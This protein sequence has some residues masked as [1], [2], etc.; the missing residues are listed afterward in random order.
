MLTKFRPA[1]LLPD[2]GGL[3]AL[4]S[5]ILL[6]L[7]SGGRSLNDG[8]TFWH[9]AAGQRMLLDGAILTRDVFSHTASGKPWTAH[10]WLSEIIMATIHGFSG[11]SGV[12]VFFFLLATLSFWLLYI[13]V[14]AK[15]S[16]WF[17]LIFVIL[18][19]VLSLN[20]LLARPHIF[21]WFLGGLSFFLLLK[22]NR[23]LLWLPLITIV[24]ANLHGGFILGLVLQGIFILGHYLECGCPRGKTTFLNW[25]RNQKY[26]L[27]VF[28]MSIVAVGLNPFGYSL[29]LFPFQVS[30][31]IFSQEIV[32]WL[33]PN[34]QKQWIFRCYLLFLIFLFSYKNVFATWTDK[35]LIIFFINA[36]L[37]HQRHIGVAAY[38][39][40]PFLAQSMEIWTSTKVN[41][42]SASNTS[43]N[44]LVLSSWS[45]PT[46]TIAFGILFIFLASS[47]FPDFNHFFHS[48]IPISKERWP[49]DAIEY[50][51]TNRPSGNMFN[52]YS[53]GGYSIYA[54]NPPQPVFIDGRADMY[55]TAIFSDYK[56][57]VRIDASINFLLDDYNIE[58]V[59][60]PTDS[61]LIRY[62]KAGG[63]WTEFYSDPLATVL[64]RSSS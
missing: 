63:Q 8:D 22:N 35:L 14:R 37:I 17:A 13:T 10:E 18:A 45:G 5:F 46:G 21:T 31:G 64:T 25:I 24:W 29:Y 49:I 28:L 41:F 36:A 19:F 44:T 54:L 50:L 16:E 6:C 1:S 23:S 9:I 59:F 3:F 12:V 43:R 61:A 57:I 47:F 51:R 58:W 20:H 56:R 62:L 11:A 40:A 15:S 38:Y 26:S 55:G 33:P 48:R 52:D 60:F 39:L 4:V 53:W 30:S 2:I 27:L 7:F 32:E 34:M 42:V